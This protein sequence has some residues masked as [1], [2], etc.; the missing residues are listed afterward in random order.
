MFQ[1]QTAPISSILI[2][3]TPFT[4]DFGSSIYKNNGPSRVQIFWNSATEPGDKFEPPPLHAC[5]ALVL[6]W[7]ATAIAASLQE[8]RK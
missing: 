7:F 5:V 1:I 4:E 2:V 3:P 8:L 6:W